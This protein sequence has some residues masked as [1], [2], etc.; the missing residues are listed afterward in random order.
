MCV[1]TLKKKGVE[2]KFFIIE[3]QAANTRI[4]FIKNKG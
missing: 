2:A 4:E 3:T 1:K